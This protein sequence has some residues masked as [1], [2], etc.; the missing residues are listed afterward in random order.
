MG[1]RRMDEAKTNPMHQA[2]V[3]VRCSLLF[4]WFWF[5]RKLLQFLDND[6]FRD[7]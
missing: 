5:F 1:V 3:K 4:K 6:Y 2:K 7:I